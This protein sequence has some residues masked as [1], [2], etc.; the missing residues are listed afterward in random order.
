[1]TQET[2]VSIVKLIYELEVR[3]SYLFIFS[4][5]CKLFNMSYT[6]QR[7]YSIVA[8]CKILG[9]MLFSCLSTEGA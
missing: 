5:G 4:S 7:S 3:L 8:C 6:T 1:M 2:A 9:V